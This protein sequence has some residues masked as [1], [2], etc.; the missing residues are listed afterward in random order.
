MYDDLLV[1]IGEMM[2]ESK[3]HESDRIGE[4]PLERNAAP[5]FLCK[6]PTCVM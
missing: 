3:T 1:V 5:I 4:H 6:G 2:S